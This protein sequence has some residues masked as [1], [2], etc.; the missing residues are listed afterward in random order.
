VSA[1]SLIR[2]ISLIPLSVKYYISLYGFCFAAR[3]KIY[4]YFVFIR[5][6]EPGVTFK[7]QFVSWV[8]KGF[9]NVDYR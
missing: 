8:E 7:E 6:Y 4:E 2:K 1:P 9:Q 5:H 3:N